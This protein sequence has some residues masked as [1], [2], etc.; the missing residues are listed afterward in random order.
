MGPSA[1][2]AI[3]TTALPRPIVLTMVGDTAETVALQRYM[4]PISFINHL[5]MRQMVS[6]VGQPS[7]SHRNIYGATFEVVAVGGTAYCG[8]EGLTTERAVY[9]D[10]RA[11]M[12]SEWF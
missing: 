11:E 1:A 4:N 12:C 8:V 2:M 9:L 3:L 10:G 6:D 7:G 5:H